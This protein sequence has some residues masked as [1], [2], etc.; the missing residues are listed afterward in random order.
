MKRNNK[1]ALY[2]KIMSDVSKTVKRS[3]NEQS[4][5]TNYSPFCNLTIELGNDDE[6]L[7]ATIRDNFDDY[8]STD[9]EL[10]ALTPDELIKKINLELM[11]YITDNYDV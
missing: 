8:N 11:E 9:K 7:Y 5:E 1:R 2:E 4:L 10:T 3:L 6:Y